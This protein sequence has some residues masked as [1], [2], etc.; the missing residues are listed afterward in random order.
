MKKPLADEVVK[1]LQEYPAFQAF[2]AY[3]MSQV[4]DLKT[5]GAEVKELSDKE[6]GE[7]TKA[8]YLAAE[9]LIAI[10]SPIINFREPNRPTQEDINRRKEAMGL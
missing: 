8:G 10:F 4:Q 2:Q 3:C 1:S 6:V 7:N 9:K 5:V